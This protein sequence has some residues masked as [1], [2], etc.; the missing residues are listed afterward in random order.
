V[1]VTERTAA[2]LLRCSC[3][4]VRCRDLLLRNFSGEVRKLCGCCRLC[5][6]LRGRLCC[7]LCCARL[8]CEEQ[9]NINERRHRIIGVH[10]LVDGVLGGTSG[11]CSPLPG[12]GLH[13]PELDCERRLM[14]RL[15]LLLRAPGDQSG[16][17]RHRLVGVSRL[18]RLFFG[19]A[20]R[21]R[22]LQPGARLHRPDLDREQLLGAGRRLVARDQLNERRHRIV[23]IVAR[24]DFFLGG[25]RGFGALAAGAG[26]HRADLVRQAGLRRRHGLLHVFCAG[27]SLSLLHKTHRRHP[28]LGVLR[29]REPARSLPIECVDFNARWAMQYEL[30]VDLWGQFS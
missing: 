15:V 11:D 17:G 4:G 9:Q 8:R 21:E 27:T 5:C 30:L 18:L 6:R 2:E 19:G 24:L 13:R 23:G 12:T 14:R 16:I 22:P 20:R 1:L 10:R 26:L 7:R 25:A 28:P 3:A 29:K